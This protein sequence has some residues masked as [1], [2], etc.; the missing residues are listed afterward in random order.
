VQWLTN[1]LVTMTFPILLESIGLGFSY[2]IYAAFGLVAYAF[3]Q[4]FVAGVKRR[5][6]EEISREAA[7][8][9]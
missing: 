2:A 8:T 5:T 4:L 1:F 7:V 9:S 3:V 6:L